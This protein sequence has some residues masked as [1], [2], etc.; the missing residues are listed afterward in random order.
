MTGFYRTGILDWLTTNYNFQADSYLAMAGAGVATQTI[1]GFFT[2]K[3]AASDTYSGGSGFAMQL[4]YDYDKFKW[5]GYS[6]S[7]RLLGEYRTHGF[8]SVGTYMA[9]INYNAY[10]AATY[11]Q[12]LPW[13]LTGGL[14]FSYYFCRPYEHF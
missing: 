8:E 7:F 6:S 9:P 14:S 4:G 12:H 1:D 5:F 11:A 10:A 3:F 13:D 2:A